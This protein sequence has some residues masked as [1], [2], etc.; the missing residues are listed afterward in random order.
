MTLVDLFIITMLAGLGLWL[1]GIVGKF[2][3]TTSTGALV[4]ASSLLLLLGAAML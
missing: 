4:G 1:F 2:K 3:K